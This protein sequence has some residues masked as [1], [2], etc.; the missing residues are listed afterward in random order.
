MTVRSGIGF[1]VHPLVAGRPLVLG[2]V[3][4]PHFSGLKRTQRW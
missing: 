3:A 4:I 1:D 2:G